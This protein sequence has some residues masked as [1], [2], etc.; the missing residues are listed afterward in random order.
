[1]HKIVKKIQ[2]NEQVTLMEVKAPHIV[3]NARPGQFIVIHIDDA[4]ERIPLTICDKDAKNGTITIIFQI[5]GATTSRLNTLGE[6]DTLRDVLGPLGHPAEIKD[7]GKVV[8]IAGGVGAAEILPVAR[9]LKEKG[10][11]VLSIIGARNK[12]LLILKDEVQA[13]SS[14]IFVTTDDGSLGHKG[15]VTDVLD[16]ELKKDKYGMIFCVGPIPMMRRTAQVAKDNG[17]NIKVSLNS[18]MVDATGMCGT[19]RI[20]VGGKTYFTCV[21]GPEFDGALVDFDELIARDKRFAK[22]EKVS[23]EEFIRDCKCANK[24]R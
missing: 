1:M 8:C 10:N 19:C 21:D 5:V 15:F 4:A 3:K 14:K 23:L 13:V 12:D 2:L 11:F 16:G 18:N 22:E 24:P 7:Y 9:A 17:A 6:D 20:S